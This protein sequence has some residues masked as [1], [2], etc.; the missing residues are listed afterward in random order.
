MDYRK[1]ELSFHEKAGFRAAVIS[2]GM[3]IGWAFYDSVIAGLAA[4]IAL[5]MTENMYKKGLLEKR[6]RRL[7]SQFKD[8]LYS[9]SSFVSTGRSLGQALEESIDFWR[10]T[11][12]DQDYIMR[13]LKQM[14]K[15]IKES[16]MPDVD[17]F[18]DFAKRSGLED[19]E[20][21]VMVCKTCKATGADFFKA[22]ER[23][24][25]I[26]EDKI[27]IE[28]E[29]S[30]IM[31]QKRFEGRMIASS[32]FGLILM[33]KILSP[34]YMAPLYETALGR[35]VSTI[36]LV[37]MAA[38]LTV[39]ERVIQIEE[40][41]ID[42]KTMDRIKDTEHM[43]SILEEKKRE[44]KRRQEMISSLPSFI[45]QILLLLNSGMVLQEAMIYI[46]V[47]Y[48]K[49][50]RERQ[51]TFIL[52]Y[53]RVYDDSM[54]TGESIIKGFYRLGRDSRV[55]ELSRVAGIIADSSRRGV[56]LW[57]KLA[58]EGEQLWRERKRTALEKI[59]LSESKMS[60]PLALLLIALILITA[61][62]AMLQM[63]ID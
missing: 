1:L 41:D 5:T 14:T 48:K 56:D 17:S 9:I 24:A 8:L 28:R 23:S 29:L 31:V 51:D 42:Y 35:A 49:L 33:I 37:L 20:D 52:E 45:N 62:P 54:K 21:F 4:G 26:I 3:M 6:R 50:D 40:L 63:Y 22:A 30:S 25:G 44:E 43:Y 13:E 32:P 53:I 15:N 57:D 60:F 27:D 47:N 55:K 38:G 61:A 18:D 39:M 12:D 46:A 59:R 34:D 16:N 10:G 19:A 7:L 11:Y 58:D 36:S 2:T